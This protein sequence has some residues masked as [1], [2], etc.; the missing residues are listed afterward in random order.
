MYYYSESN[1]IRSYRIDKRES[2]VSMQ[3]YEQ[4][5]LVALQSAGFS[6]REMH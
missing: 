5:V 2:D 6:G 4:P 3:D 1:E